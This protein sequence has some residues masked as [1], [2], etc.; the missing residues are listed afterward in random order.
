MRGTSKEKK[1]MKMSTTTTEQPPEPYEGSVGTGSELLKGHHFYRITAG[2]ITWNGIVLRQLDQY[3]LLEVWD[4]FTGLPSARHVLKIS[5]L[6]W[7]ESSKTGFFLYPDSDSSIHSYHHGPVSHFEEPPE[8]R[9]AK[10]AAR[11]KA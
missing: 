10:A 7:D 6:V 9:E 8:I 3:V 5:D 1:E 11:S 4:W 2:S